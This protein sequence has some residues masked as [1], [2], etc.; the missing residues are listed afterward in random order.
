[1]DFSLLGGRVSVTADYYVKTSDQL[2]LNVELPGTAG[3]S[4]TFLFNLGEVQNRGF[5]FDVRTQNLTGA[6][7]GAPTSTFRRSKTRSP[8]WA[9][10]R[11]AAATSTWATASSSSTG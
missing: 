2:L 3:A 4:P 1:V 10:T 5:E 11:G 9:P 6:S 8:A 7:A